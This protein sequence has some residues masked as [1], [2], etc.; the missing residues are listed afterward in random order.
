MPRPAPLAWIT[1]KLRAAI[2]TLTSPHALVPQPS[3]IELNEPIDRARKKKET[4]G[5]HGPRAP[6][7][8]P[9]LLA[10]RR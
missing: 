5:H 10:D 9:H 1:R 2:A 4:A 7:G 8:D 6:T 3:L